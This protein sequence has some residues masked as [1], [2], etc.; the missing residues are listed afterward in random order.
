MN[1]KVGIN[2]LSIQK[3]WKNLQPPDI[4]QL[5]QT[6]QKF[7]DRTFPPNKN[8]LI[9]KN[10]YGEFVD[11]YRGPEQLK[12]FEE[13]NPGGADRLEWRRVT[14]ISPKWELFEG[15]IEFND[16]QQGSLGDCYFLSS[17]TALTEYP[18]LIKEKFRTQ[19][20]NEEGYYEVIF[21]I[22]GEWQI[23]FL[24]DYF[25]YD[26]RKRT[27]AFARP[28]N[29]ELWAMLLEKAWAKLNG[30][31][32]NI[33]G[34]IVSE[35]ISA[36]TGFPT[37]Y[38]SHK[39]LE[40]EDI[41]AK[42]EEGDKEGTIMSSAS[43]GNNE[44]EARGLVQSHAYTLIGA[45]KWVQRH[46][47]LLKLRNPW[48]EGEW[49]GKWSDNSPC[50]TN[51]YKSYFNYKK[52]NDG[53]FWIDIGDYVKNFDATY[54]C[55][56]LYGA[57]VKNFYFEY[58]SYFKKPVIFNMRVRQRSK[59]S[60]S[61]LFKCWRFNREIKD[62]SHPFSLIVCKYDNYR[63]IEKLWGNWSCKDDMNIIEFF[64]PGYYVIWLYLA[65]KGNNDPNFRY[66]VQVSS[67]EDF[68]IEF[69]GLDH[70]FLLIQYL[71]LENYKKTGAN[72]LASSKDYFIGT[73]RDISKA[74]LSNLLLYNKT[75][76]DVEIKASGKTV[77]N[78]QLL[79]PYEGLKNIKINLPP[80]ESVAIVAIRLSNNATNFSYGFQLTMS[81]GNKNYDPD[82]WKQTNGD[83][84]ANYLKFNIINNN[85]ETM[86]L[87]TG[88]Y[89]YVG[90]NLAQLM[91]KFDAT[92]F[93]GKSILQMATQRQEQVNLNV[94]QK[95]YPK[96]MELLLKK[97]PVNRNENDK[98]WDFV[99]SNDGKY[100]GQIN[101]RTGNL[102][103]KGV[104]IWNNGIKYIGNWKEGSMTGEG[105]L[106][107][108]NNRLIFE[109]NYYNNKKYG[110]G[111]FII[112]DNEY[113]EGEFFDD[114]MEGKGTYYYQNGDK[115][116]G[117][118]KN[119]MK[120]GVGIMTYHNSKDVYLYE[121]ENDNY[122]GATQLNSQEI[123][124]VR[125]LQQEERK[126]ILENEKK[127]L[128][129]RESQYVEQ[130]KNK[131]N[132]E[133]GLKNFANNLFLQKSVIGFVKVTQMNQEV[134]E[135]EQEKRHRIF[136]E[137]V[138]LFKKKE[139]FMMEKFLDLR[140]LNYEEDLQLVHQGANKYLGGMVKKGQSTVMQGRGVL[141]DGKYYYAGYWD[142][143]EPNGFF[144][145]YN[146]DKVIN[147]QGFLLRDYTIDPSKIG[148]AF[149]RN[150]ERYE[151]YFY[152]NRMHGFGT[153]YFPTGNSFTGTFNNGQFDGTGKYFYDN[154]LISEIITYQNNKIVSKYQKMRDDYRDPN[155]YNF[156]NHIKSTY[157]GVM[158][159]ILEVPPL[160][161]SKGELYW[162]KHVYNNNDIYIGQMDF[163]K[164][165]LGRCCIIYVNSRITY[166]VGYIKNKEFFGEGTYYDYQWNKIYEGTFEH[167]KK[168]GFG[169]LWREDG[170]TYAGQFIDD[171][172]NGKGV[173]YY[174]ND[175]RFEGT[176]VNGLPNDKG[177]LISGDNLTKQEIVYNM[178]NII[179]QGEK[180]DYRKG[181]CRKQFRD[182]FYEF[183][184][185]C[186]QYGYDKFMNLMMNIKP[187]KDSYMLKK[188]IKEEVS[189]IYIGEM[190]TV[191]FKYGRGVFIDS[192]N[193]MFYV[194]YFVNNEKFGKGVNYY[195]NGK[196]Q[197]VGEYRRNKTVGKGEFRYQNGE[198]LQGTFN[199]VG[200]GQGVFTFDDGAYWRGS[201]YAWTLT[202]NGTY[203]TKDGY[204]LG[205]KAYE[206]NKPI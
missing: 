34:G 133:S 202:G 169:I 31:Y 150:G 203:Y 82:R 129:R 93:V 23:L 176:F 118:F 168:S 121:F 15:K 166:F 20:F 123:A 83:K 178:G 84:F 13:D 21:F 74:G 99:K 103:G 151:G 116:E 45:K 177:Y 35:P 12:D 136:L 48:G 162:V 141:Y 1:N 87:R 126:R 30:G 124:S 69:L 179:E 50:W 5:R 96:E 163:E 62:L 91:P 100:L 44:V 149:F 194:G 10:Q 73:D 85:P 160:R 159:H 122:M 6:R 173:L 201:F 71:L 127:I 200:E 79:P 40:E 8:S 172:P 27:F 101:M 117:Y 185:I 102:E 111:R 182:E 58:Q 33:V 75:G 3:Y 81:G 26:P 138:E 113:Y 72:N 25:P 144:F 22:D 14:D 120:N 114:K 110:H 67:L 39:N 89:K 77:S 43:K 32:S 78:V 18:F 192:Y 109:G 112:K 60:V 165:F 147:F 205:Q 105:V 189:G 38:L 198:V 51:E 139:S 184:K 9:S 53:I 196:Q 16:V 145:R 142:N 137:N 157:P 90:K 7:Y 106:F 135:T 204:C 193:N 104:Y 49:N 11:K 94:L 164:N 180:T 88:E 130:Q 56:I 97:F 19:Q 119:N 154:G 115:W 55:Y 188:G 63:R 183:E 148:K 153:Y 17:I 66:T 174:Q 92:Q 76:K 197:Y 175:S 2:P 143:N 155:S 140:P 68:D 131:N 28:H 41:Y 132:I 152:K 57:I 42:I 65:T 70:N 47:Y 167:N 195:P 80:Y 59:M 171:Q 54:I 64:E 186:K 146:K 36:L 161:D 156:I 125:N 98:K 24:D 52:A 158:E 108:K 107:D 187:T 46:L 206:Y 61:V 199:S 190:N 37:E 29:N 191:G 134:Q 95:Y 128:A 181:S 4:R 170:S 86:G